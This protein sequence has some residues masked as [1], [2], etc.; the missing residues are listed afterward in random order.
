MITTTHARPSLH[1]AVRTMTLQKAIVCTMCHQT[2]G[3]VSASVSAQTLLRLHACTAAS[4]HG[5]PAIA[6]PF[7]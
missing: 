4:D 2:L 5:R 1:P 3:M 7:S 6:V